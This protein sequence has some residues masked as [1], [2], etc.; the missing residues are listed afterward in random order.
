TMACIKRWAASNTRRG[1]QWSDDSGVDQCSGPAR[2]LCRGPGGFAD[3]PY[4]VNGSAQDRYPLIHPV[5]DASPPTVV[6]VLATDGYVGESITVSA[7]I[8]DPSGVTYAALWLQG[9][10]LDHFDAVPM[11]PQ[12]GNV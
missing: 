1:Y 2:N 6:Q 8:T 9:I 10:G 11:R 3:T 4:L 12:G 5:F 7:E